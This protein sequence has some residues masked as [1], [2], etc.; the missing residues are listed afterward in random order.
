M[1]WF[2]S[3]IE[4]GIQH[5]KDPYLQ[6]RLRITN[7]IALIGIPSALAY[8]TFYVLYFPPLIP[9][10]IASLFLLLSVF[11][12]NY[13]G[14]LLISKIILSLVILLLVCIIHGFAIPAG[15]A[16]STALLLYTFCITF[17]PW[18][19]FDIRER[20]WLSLSVLFNMI[21]FLNQQ[22]FIDFFE[23][24]YNNSLF[25]QP[26]FIYFIFYSSV[27]LFNLFMFIFNYR[28]YT[29]E[30]SVDKLLN[31]MSLKNED[32]LQ[33]Q[34][35]ISGNIK[36]ME[37]QKMQLEQ[38]NWLEKGIIE[39]NAYFQKNEEESQLY[40]HLLSFIVRHCKA[41]QGAL[42]VL[43]EKREE[44]SV[45]MVASYAIDQQKIKQKSFQLGEGLI[46]Q[47]ALEKKMI[48]LEQVPLAYATIE[49]GQ[50]KS[51]IAYVWITPALFQEKLQAVIEIGSF[52][53][54][55]K[56]HFQFVEE[57][58]KNL[59][60]WLLN[61]RVLQKTKDLLRQSEEQSQMFQAQEE[62]MRSVMEDL[63]RQQ[64]DLL[65]KEKEYKIMSEQQSKADDSNSKGQ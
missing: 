65:M 35:M 39:S 2:L 7:I 6:N 29:S 57:A 32:L 8:L 59:A 18:L 34:E 14:F 50:G 3:L 63:S 44:Q 26:F 60:A 52:E 40:T 20:G 12:F 27:I 43:N 56:Q 16:P 23:T 61:N 19:I 47:C 17:L 25:Y 33:K 30:K 53:K 13:L 28:T 31:E 21:L 37:E 41:I 22:F 24:K 64:Q 46:G 45:E 55:E 4:V 51:N 62:Y 9:Y 36:L 42:Y 38:K 48:S 5:S 49:S 54:P 11:L 1:N 15:Q 58:G 10:L